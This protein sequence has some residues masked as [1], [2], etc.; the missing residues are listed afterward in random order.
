MIISPPN[1][2]ATGAKLRLLLDERGEACPTVD[3][4]LATPVLPDV[5]RPK[6]IR[7]IMAEAA[8]ARD[9]GYFTGGIVP[10]PRAERALHLRV[11]Y[12]DVEM[13]PLPDEQAA[14]QV[15]RPHEHDISDMLIAGFFG[16][17]LVRDVLAA[18]QHNLRGRR[19][20]RWHYRLFVGPD[21][22]TPVAAFPANGFLTWEERRRYVERMKRGRA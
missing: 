18:P 4:S 12:L 1:I 20:D 13:G 14:E 7:E 21:W 2:I 15:Y 16:E 19:A 8:V 17:G 5:S 6:L 9:V 10:F 22:K 3:V 11:A